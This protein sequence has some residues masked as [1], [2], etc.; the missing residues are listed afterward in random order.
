MQSF[1]TV[2]NVAD[3]AYSCQIFDGAGRTIA[4]SSNHP[5][6]TGGYTGQLTNY[7]VMG[8]AINQTKPTEITG[9]WV[10]VGDDVGWVYTLQAYDWK[11]RP[12]ET[13]LPDG[14]TRLN[15]YGGCGCAG[16]EVTTVR[17]ENGRRRSTPWT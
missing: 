8:R 13:I 15:T 12:T 9:T 2:N 4:H 11:G 17:D 5:G 14:A 16:G 3:E 6:S 7:D 1:S 10:P